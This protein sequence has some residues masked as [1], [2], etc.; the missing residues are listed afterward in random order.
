MC[1]RKRNPLSHFATCGFLFSW[2][3]FFKDPAGG[4][5]VF[6][7]EGTNPSVHLTV[8]EGTDDGALRHR[9]G[10]NRFDAIGGGYG[11]VW[12]HHHSLELT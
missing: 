12:V 9:A 1:E 10:V 6:D 3:L 2:V 8:S 5:V 4:A 7:D 11:D